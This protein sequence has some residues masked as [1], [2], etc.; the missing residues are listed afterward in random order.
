MYL[1]FDTETTGLPA[2][3][4]APASDLDNWPRMIQLAW[5][6]YDKNGKEVARYENIIKPNGFDIPVESSN[7]HGITTEM[8]IKNGVPLLDALK[9]FKKALDKSKVLVAHNISFDEKVIGAE[10]LREHVESKIFE[11]NK[12]CTMHATTNYCKI[13]GR[14]GYKWPTLMELHNTVFGYGFDGAHDA[15]VDVEACAKCFFKLKN[16]GIIR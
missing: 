9:G 10:Y 7:V 1:F 8:A 2:N 6:Q 12:Q 14:Y 5:L 13:P 16:D 15:L 11:I 4:K 3:Y